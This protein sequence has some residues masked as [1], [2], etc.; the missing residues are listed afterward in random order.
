MQSKMNNIKI[1][2]LLAVSVL[3]QG[4]GS[5]G[6]M[7]KGLLPTGSY[8]SWNNVTLVAEDDANLNSAIAVDVVMLHDEE[9]LGLLQNMPATKWFAS[10]DDLLKTFPKGLSFQTAELVPG[11]TLQ[12]KLDMFQQKRQ[13]G[14]LVFANYLTPGEHRVRVDFLKGQVL[15]QLSTKSFTVVT[16]NP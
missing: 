10:R 6:S 13:V 12:L 14:T 11:Q 4:C 8:L 1:F 5:G 7:F 15:I 9:T 16:S 2:F 3:L